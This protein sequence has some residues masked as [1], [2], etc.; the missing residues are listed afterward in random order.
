MALGCV[1][2]RHL[3]VALP[4]PGAA[5]ARW[6]RGYC[7]VKPPSTGTLAPVMNPAFDDARNTTTSAISAGWELRP[8]GCDAAISARI[9]SRSGG[10]ASKT[11]RVLTP[12][13]PPALPRRP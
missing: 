6:A 13:A 5:L 4:H 9:G 12:P 2:G 1:R 11:N 10:R 3:D 8:I 7:A